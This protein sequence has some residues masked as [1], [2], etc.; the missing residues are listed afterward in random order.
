M[1]TTHTVARRTVLAGAGASLLAA[2]AVHGQG[3]TS[4]VAL[5]VGN[6]K[7]QWEAQLPNVKRDAPDIARRFQDFGLKTELIQDVGR[8]AF[9]RA[10]ERLDAS[11]RGAG[12]AALYFAGHG[13]FQRGVTSLVPVDVDLSSPDVLKSIPSTRD[14]AKAMTG[15]GHCLLVLDNCRNN[16]SD[17]WRQR[18]AQDAAGGF[19]P[20]AYFPGELPPHT[21]I[22]F[23][24]AP[25]RVAL[26]GPAGDNSPFAAAL[27]RQLAGGSVDLQTLPTNLRRD[28]MIA[29]E[30]CQVMI[31]MGRSD[32]SYQMTGK[33]EPSARRNPGDLSR[34][35]ELTNSYAEAQKAGLPMLPGLVACRPAG[36]SSDG[37]KVGGYLATFTTGEP[38]VMAVLTV[39]DPQGVELVSSVKG[40]A[41]R[42]GWRLIRGKLAGDS[43]EFFPT[44]GASKFVFKWSGAGGGAFTAFPPQQASNQS[45]IRSGTFKRLDG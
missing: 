1:T 14:F 23:S 24:T 13:V 6:S 27:L 19:G 42:P 12:L 31:D 16:P 10:I 41:G 37:Q 7:Y 45:Q 39:D 4:G 36:K 21:Q 17:G 30:G 2:P 8:D 32:G 11:A 9:K 25:G 29:T 20:Q 44:D 3:R 15:A 34:V 5:V 35:V 38:M 26:D 22:L 40:K 28:L 18:E 43:L 33:P